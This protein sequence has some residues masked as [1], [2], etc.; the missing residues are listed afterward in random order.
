LARGPDKPAPSRRASWISSYWTQAP[1]ALTVPLLP[2]WLPSPAYV[3]LYVS[4]AGE[5]RVVT[6]VPFAASGTV[7]NV[8]DESLKTTLPVGV[9]PALAGV[10]VAVNVTVPQPDGFGSATSDVVVVIGVQ[11]GAVGIA[12]Q[13][14]GAGGSDPS[15]GN[16]HSPEQIG[17][18]QSSPH[19]VELSVIPMSHGDVGV[20][21]HEFVRVWW[22]FEA[23]SV[24]LH[25]P[26]EPQ[27]DSSMSSWPAPGPAF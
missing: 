24:R 27:A 6:A 17:G 5:F 16:V 12:S 1:P 11:P 20:L 4:D 18:V 22:S 13:M 14:F 21:V 8:P 3:A 9:G 2:E 23:F 7:A 26:L 19:G 15:G 10:T 25:T